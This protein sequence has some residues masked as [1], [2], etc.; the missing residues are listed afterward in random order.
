MT[1]FVGEGSAGQTVGAVQ[2]GAET[3]YFHAQVSG[4]LSH[5]LF[6]HHYFL[7]ALHHLCRILGQ[8]IDELEVGEASYTVKCR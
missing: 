7:V 8:R 2:A 6:G 1:A 5:V 3:V 4:K